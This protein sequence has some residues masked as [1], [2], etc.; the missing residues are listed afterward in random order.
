M[1]EMRGRLD[2]AF[3]LTPEDA[4]LEADRAVFSRWT[5]AHAARELR[6][7]EDEEEVTEAVV[8]E[9]ESEEDE[10]E[11]PDVV[12]VDEAVEEGEEEEE[13]GEV[14]VVPEVVEVEEG[15]EAEEVEEEEEDVVEEP[16]VGGE[17]VPVV[18]EIEADNHYYLAGASPG[19]GR[20][21]IAVFLKLAVDGSSA[22]SLEVAKVAQ[23]AP[24]RET[25]VLD[26][27]RS[28]AGGVHDVGSAPFTMF[29]DPEHGEDLNVQLD[30]VT[31]IMVSLECPLVG[32]AS[33]KIF[34]TDNLSW[35][36]VNIQQ[37][38]SLSGP[39]PNPQVR[40][41]ERR[42]LQQLFDDG[43]LR[44]DGSDQN[45]AA[46]T[47]LFFLRCTRLGLPPHTLVAPP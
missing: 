18:D 41:R 1:L 35:A 19:A 26:G 9:E 13:E 32:V 23:T 37:P 39:Q 22:P 25:V 38:L 3:R 7:D 29:V 5:A 6:F 27:V 20:G 8:E 14:A 42:R 46:V 10:I 43:L 24:S 11:E 33:D 15:E 16:E 28:R 40:E 45:G 21:E 30:V 47:E 31:S 34:D 2:E 17:A 12:E 44:A 36:S 4:F